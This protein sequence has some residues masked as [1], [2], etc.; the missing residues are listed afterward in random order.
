MSHSEKHTQKILLPYPPGCITATLLRREKR[1]LVEV[2][3][4][5]E[6]FW[7]HTNNSGSMLGLVRPGLTILL[8]P[9]DNPKRKYKYTLEAIN[10]GSFWVGVNTLVPNRL[11]PEALKA[12]ALPAPWSYK[13]MRREVNF[14]DSRLDLLLTGTNNQ[15]CYIEAKNVTLVEEDV[16][17][18][19]DAQTKRGGK[20]L[21]TLMQA[22]KQGHNAC[23]FFLVQRADG[24]CFGPADF[25]D[26]EYASLFWQALDSGVEMWPYRAR[27]TP[28]GIALA[29]R[30]PLSRP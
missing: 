28:Q 30:L 6:T 15:L 1:F 23:C 9:S 5:K 20:H 29:E 27:V 13:D 4:G 22:V 26:P 11:L 12:G 8:S 2:Q 18:F 14:Q 10:L 21:A 17:Y 16:A 7:A 25:I 19:P 24:H 3:K